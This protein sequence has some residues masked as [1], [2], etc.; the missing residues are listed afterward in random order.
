MRKIFSIYS[1]NA[2]KK[3]TSGGKDLGVIALKYPTGSSISS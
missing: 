3:G 2:N 1:K